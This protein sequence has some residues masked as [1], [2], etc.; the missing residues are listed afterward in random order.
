[1]MPNC[2]HEYFFSRYCGASVCDKCGDHRG[3]ARCYCG[4]PHGEKLEDDIG[5][6]HWD[7]ETWEVD[8]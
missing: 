2:R 4:W 6:P 5:E 8:Y 3:L 7:G 1:M